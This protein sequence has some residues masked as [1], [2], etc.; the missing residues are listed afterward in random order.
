MNFIQSNLT[1]E[2][3]GEFDEI[4]ANLPTSQ[5]LRRKL[6]REVACDPDQL[7]LAELTVWI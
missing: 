6:G 7:C 3:D 1:E 5:T 4:V 2:I